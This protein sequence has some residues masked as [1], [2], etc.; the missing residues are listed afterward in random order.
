MSDVGT[1]NRDL[2]ADT[3]IRSH[4]EAA[5]AYHRPHPDTDFVTQTIVERDG[6]VRRAREDGKE[7]REIRDLKPGDRLRQTI[8]NAVGEAKLKAANTPA[9]EQFV[10]DGHQQFL[11]NKPPD[12]WSDEAKAEFEH[13]PESV[14]LS[15]LREA[16]YNANVFGRLA[17]EYGE[18]RKAIEPHRD[19]IPQGLKE[20]EVIGNMFKWYRELRGPNR[21]RA[22]AELMNQTGGIINVGQSQQPPQ[23]HQQQQ[24][25][26]ADAYVQQTLARFAQDHPH[27]ENVRH[28]MGQMAQAAPQ[29]FT[30]PNGQVDLERLYQAALQHASQSHG[31]QAEAEMQ[32]RLNAFA[33][34]HPYFASVRRTMGALLQA[35][36]NK[37][38]PTG[39]EDLEKL[40]NDALKIEGHS[41]E[42]KKKAAVSPSNR[43]PAASQTKTEK[44]KGI[45]AAIR[46]AISESREGRI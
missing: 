35:N 41:K 15:A 43:S 4:V 39:S 40:Y 9:K 18:I 6:A 11:H 27:F 45:R 16:N 22:F 32:E 21:E 36:P 3:G 1:E 5:V 29:A 7:V 17:A 24:P 30:G 20:P 38:G 26:D 37:Y 23:Q 42:D 34:S 14:R 8:R 31:G 10:Q 13:L 44:S 25:A 19:L 28:V 33:E 46:N 2:N 12:T